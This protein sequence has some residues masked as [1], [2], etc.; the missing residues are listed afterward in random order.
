MAAPIREVYPEAAVTNWLTLV[1]T[2]EAPTHSWRGTPHPASGPTLF[3]HSS[4]AA[5]GIDTG[6]RA[7]FS[8]APNDKRQLPD[9]LFL[10]ILLRQAS[11]DAAN[12][13]R[14]APYLGGVVWVARWVPDR[15]VTPTPVM[16]RR[17]YREALRHLWL[18][19]MDAMAVFNPDRV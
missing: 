1:S 15:E 4:P 12:R 6:F 5:Y 13:S 14:V 9:W 17:M 3:T 19:G 18:R 2:P 10:H 7:Q 11:E 16:S 8:D